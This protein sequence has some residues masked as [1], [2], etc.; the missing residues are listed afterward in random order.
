MQRQLQ[1]NINNPNAK[2]CILDVVKNINVK[3]FNLMSTT[4]ETRQ[5]KWHQ[6]CKCKCRL[7]ARVYNNKQWWNNEKCR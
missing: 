2:L 1:Y 4:N 7:D 5:I 3:L 6:T